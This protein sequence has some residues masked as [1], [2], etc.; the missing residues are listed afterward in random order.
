VIVHRD[1]AECGYACDR[2]S[3]VGRLG[4]ALGEAP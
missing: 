1:D 3:H 2:K 4:H